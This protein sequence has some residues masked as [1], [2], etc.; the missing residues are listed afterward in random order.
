MERLF[1]A[2]PFLYEIIFENKEEHSWQLLLKW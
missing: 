2:H 1:L